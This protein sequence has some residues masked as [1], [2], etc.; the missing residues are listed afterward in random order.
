MGRQKW[1]TARIHC[2][3]KGEPSTQGRNPFTERDEIFIKDESSICVKYL[4]LAKLQDK[5]GKR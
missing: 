2:A 5:N 1:K 4:G 3:E